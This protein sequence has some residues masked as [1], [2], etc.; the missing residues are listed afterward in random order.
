MKA[1]VHADSSIDWVDCSNSISYQYEDEDV[2]MEPIYKYF[3]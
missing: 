3:V 2:Y 1:A